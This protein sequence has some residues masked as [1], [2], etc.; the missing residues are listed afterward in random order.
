MVNIHEK[1]V[2]TS[3]F[4]CFFFMSVTLNLA[5]LNYLSVLFF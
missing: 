1:K 2:H 3:V 4:K 5:Y